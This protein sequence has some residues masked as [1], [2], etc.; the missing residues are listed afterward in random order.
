MAGE[1]P[2][3]T[4]SPRSVSAPRRHRHHRS[5][6][7]WWKRL[8]R[9]YSDRY[10][11]LRPRNLVFY[12]IALSGSVLVAYGVSHCEMGETHEP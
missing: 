6:R 4:D 12:A 9:R 2:G 5:G 11:G 10:P 3:G 1:T 7:P 8:A